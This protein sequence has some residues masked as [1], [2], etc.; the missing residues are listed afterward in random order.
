MKVKYFIMILIFLTLL[1][2]SQDGL[3]SDRKLGAAGAVELLIPM[4]ARSIGMGGSNI[5]NVYGTEAMYWNPAGLALLSGLE[6]SFSYMTYFAD[7]NIS[8][9]TAGS[10]VGNLGV[11]GLSL[12]T[13]NIGDIFVTTIENPG[14]TG[15]VLRPNFLTLNASFS[16][17]FTDR[18]NFG[19]NAKMI[20]ERI[21]NMSASAIAFDFGL[22]YRSPF[23]VDFGVVMRNIGTHLKY[24]G[25]GIEFDSDIPWANPNAT[26]RKTKLD[27]ATHELPASLNMG[28][29]YRYQISEMHGI[30]VSGIYSNNSFCTD[31]INAGLEYDFKDMFFL[32]AGYN[33]AL[34]PETT[35]NGIAE[36]Q[37]GLTLGFGLH[38]SVG[39]KTIMV[40][41]AY[42]DMDLFSANQYFSFGFAL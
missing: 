15:E 29:A 40:D 2:G 12:Q 25:T 30:N 18:I 26:T 32:R 37:Y 13:F 8:Y 38:F 1:I 24:K 42:R 27:M 39:G 28:V 20:S 17:H 7:M 11:I 33:H 9:F 3:T 35:P 22:Q 36:Y 16:R 23:G 31:Q 19:M 34:Y 5:A 41:Y 10:N 14:G 6:A 4:G 21:G